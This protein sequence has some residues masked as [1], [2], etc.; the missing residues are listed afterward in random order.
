[1]PAK[2]K[3][4]NIQPCWH[5]DYLPGGLIHIFASMENIFAGTAQYLPAQLNI[6]RHS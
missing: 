1:V 2:W 3:I 5:S 4:A 6:S